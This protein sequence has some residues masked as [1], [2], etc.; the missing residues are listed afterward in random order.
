M[1]KRE[2]PGR[3]GVSLTGGD[4]MAKSPVQAA[5]G[6]KI[7]EAGGL[8]GR[9]VVHIGRSV[10]I[11]GEV[12]ASEDLTIEGQV[13]GKIEMSQHVLTVGPNGKIKAQVVAKAVVVMGTVDGNITATEKIDIREKATVNGDLVSPRVHIVDGAYF[14]GSINMQRSQA[15]KAPGTRTGKPPV[16]PQPAG[17]A[18]Y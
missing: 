6:Q 12:S 3:P 4:T 15:S 7:K 14:R 10:V 18:H 8:L 16:P 17:A 11:T 1:W 5:S 13:D 9:D 2:K